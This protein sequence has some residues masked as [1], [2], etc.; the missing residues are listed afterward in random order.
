MSANEK[1][2]LID[3]YRNRDDLSQIVT[4]LKS[5]I[6]LADDDPEKLYKNY[7]VFNLI[8]GIYTNSLVDFSLAEKYNNL[9]KNEINRLLSEDKINKREHTELVKAYHVRNIH[10]LNL[11][12]NKKALAEYRGSEFLALYKD[13]LERNEKVDCSSPAGSIYCNLEKAIDSNDKN[14]IVENYLE[15]TNTIKELDRKAYKA[16]L[17]RNYERQKELDSMD[18]RYEMS[19]LDLAVHVWTTVLGAPFMI[20]MMMYYV[21]D[22]Y[23]HM[24]NSFSVFKRDSLYDLE[25]EDNRALNKLL[26]PVKQIDLFYEVAKAAEGINNKELAISFIL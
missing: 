21:P 17:M 8:A 25:S 10:I 7:E 22:K 6:D 19:S 16:S 14:G 5:D 12:F 18:K 9:F 23:N 2:S 15:L 3:T 20:P 1:K 4:L 11:T 13:L 24:K 26:S